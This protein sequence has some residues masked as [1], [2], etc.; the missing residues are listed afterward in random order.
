MC[1]DIPFLPEATHQIVRSHHERWDRTDYPDGL[2]GS[3]IPFPARLF[4][5]V[6]VFDALTTE[7]GYKQ[8]WPVERALMEIERLGGEHFGTEDGRPLRQ[9]SNSGPPKRC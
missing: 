1:A 9:L 5:M 2:A 4:A 8:D 7:R 6:D 3:D